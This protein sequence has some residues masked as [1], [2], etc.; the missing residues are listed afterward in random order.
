MRRPVVDDW[1][2]A[3]K[4]NSTRVRFAISLTRPMLEFLCAAADGVHWDR[5]AFGGIT[6]P[7]NWI[8]TEYALKKRGLIIRKPPQDATKYSVIP[9]SLTPAGVALVELLKVG[10]LFIESNE[11][12]E[13][14]AARKGRH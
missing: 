8:S 12:V 13:K 4:S 9:W 5:R 14:M 6:F 1:Q 7:D 2:D 10:G 11:A 3:F